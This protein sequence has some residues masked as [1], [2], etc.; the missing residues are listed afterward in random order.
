MSE[1][2]FKLLQ[3]RRSCNLLTLAEM[4][5]GKTPTTPT[6]SSIIAAVQCQEA[7]KILHGME[8]I[9]VGDSFD[10]RDRCAIRVHERHETAVHEAAVNH[11]RA[12]AALPFAASFLGAGQV[13]LAAQRVQQA[14]HR[15]AAQLDVV[16][17]HATADGN[18]SIRQATAP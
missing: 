4:E 1:T 15:V 8:S 18:R 6:I 3:M 9:A 10:R 7:V 13:Q 14:R 16:A 12:R 5:G 2:D 17:I 11:D